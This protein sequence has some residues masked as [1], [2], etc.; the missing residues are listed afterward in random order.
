M[1]QWLYEMVDRNIGCRSMKSARVAIFPF[2]HFECEI[3]APAFPV[4]C[5]TSG[6]SAVNGQLRKIISH[7]MGRVQAA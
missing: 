4:Q 7:H 3:K 6:A 2:H 1:P 5:I